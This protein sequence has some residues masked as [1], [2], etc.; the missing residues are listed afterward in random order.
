M[1]FVK[2]K[3]ILDK[4]KKMVYHVNTIKGSSRRIILF[5]TASVR[6][7]LCQSVAYINGKTFVEIGFYI[8]LYLNLQ[9][10]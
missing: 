3:F 10:Q 5:M 2:I 1:F 6:L 7:A 4:M 9:V 8:F